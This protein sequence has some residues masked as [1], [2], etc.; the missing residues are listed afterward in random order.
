MKFRVLA[1]LTAALTLTAS[2][3]ALPAVHAEDSY[4][5]AVSIDLTAGNK[6]IS[7]YIFGINDAGMLDSVTVNAVRQGGNRYSAYNWENNFS[8]AGADWKNNS[9]TYLV[10]GMTKEQSAKPG[11]PAL[12]LSEDCVKHNIPYKMT[13]VQMAGYVSA[14]GDGAVSESEKAPSARWKEVK[15]AKGS[16][17][18]LTP[19]TT[20][21]AVYMD[22]YVNYLVK[23]LGDS[24][25]KEGINGY[26]LD[27]EP[28]LWDS[29]HSLMHPDDPTYQEMVDKSTAYAS[30]IKS[31][32]PKAEVF[33]LALFGVYSYFNF[34]DAPDK[35]SSYNW[36]LDYY[37]DNMSKAEKTAGKRLIDAIDV[38]YYSEA[39][40]D[41][42]VTEANAT[43]DKDK[44]A[45]VQAPR[46]LYEDGY[47]EVSWVTDALSQYMP[48]IPTIQASIDKYYPGT[49]LAITEYNF[50]G[51][52]DST[53]AIAEADALG[54]FAAN[55]VY[56][57]TLWPLS[58]TI[59]YQLSAIN[60]YTNYDG[61]GGAFGDTL[62][63]AKTADIEK[64]YAYASIDGTDTSTVKV[65]MANKDSEKTEK[66]TFDIKGGKNYK[67]A[68]VYA[69]T[70]DNSDIRVIDVQNDITSDSITVSLPPYSVATV[71]LSEENSKETTYVEPE[72]TTSEVVYQYADLKDGKDGKIIPIADPD[73]LKE[74][75]IN[76]TASSNA[77][78]TWYC[79]GGAL[80]FNSL[81]TADGNVWAAKSFMYNGTGDVKIKFDG[82][83]SI[84]DP[85]GGDEM[86]V[87][88]GKITEDSMTFQ[89]WW[90]SSEKSDA[91]E[92][93]ECTYNTITLVYDGSSIVVPSETP[94]ETPSEAPTEEPTEEPTEQPTEAPEPVKDN[95]QTFKFD[96]LTKDKDGNFVVPIEDASKLSAV[97]INTTCECAADTTW[98]GGGGG[99]CFAELTD[100]DGTKFWGY[101]D[102][103]YASGTGDVT[104]K[105]DGKFMKPAEND[106]EENTEVAATIGD[107]QLVVQDWWKAT[108]EDETGAD[109]SVTYNT[110]TLVYEG[111][112]NPTETP[113]DTPEKKAAYGDV[114]ED[115]GVDILDVIALN[116]YLLGS[117]TLSEQGK[118]NADVDNSGT[119]DSTDSLNILKAV[120]EIIDVKDFPIKG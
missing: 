9:D 72:K 27:N 8:N 120:V 2:L 31:V 107:K 55:D 37:L 102:F 88:E 54:A 24:T 69:V 41:A 10:N 75:I 35:D 16:E 39:K 29:T 116:R 89:D 21:D 71:V 32:D 64:S 28:G 92:D 25:T 23:T 61:K 101:K 19:D 80:C 96:D 86:P 90:K 81:E 79:G 17:F 93:V 13:T 22:E 33:G 112:A 30:A 47:R 113:T 73:H 12:K 117:T 11:A 66:A 70:K 7:P 45:R 67:S 26:N 1:A 114:N 53:G 4:D 115:N 104:V 43:S 60:L 77:G 65:V 49:K 15:P 78:S 87:V 85:D 68:V 82:T 111:S 14:D 95:E 63:E 36:F 18:S 6:K 38:H 56:L 94:S 84:A 76:V 59:D 109:V 74:V 119:P 50:G 100:A 46:T 52:M 48:F 44:A 105:M 42:R 51:G 58:D 98:F 91:G 110:I 103:Q 20:D 34:C 40:G 3:P 57:A 62:V 97:V 5:M 108:A 118:V 106:G 83:F 99:I